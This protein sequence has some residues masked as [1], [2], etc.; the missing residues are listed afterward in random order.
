MKMI[1]KDNLVFATFFAGIALI[2]Y[3]IYEMYPSIYFGDEIILSYA[4]LF[5]LNSVG[6]TIFYLGNNG[7]FKIDFAQLYLVFTTIQMLG[8]FSFAAYVKFKFEE[9]AKVALIQFV[10]LFFVSLVFQTI[11]LVKTKVR[12]TI[13]D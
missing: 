7:T 10:I 12:K 3:G 4:L 2:H 9:N 6:A 8:C 13:T 5:I 1:L 11:Y